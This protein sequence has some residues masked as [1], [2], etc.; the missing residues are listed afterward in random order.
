MRIV[1]KPLRSWLQATP[2]S[3]RFP[4][5]SLGVEQGQH[6]SLMLLFVLETSRSLVMLD[7]QWQHVSLMHLFMLLR[8]LA[9]SS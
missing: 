9:A 3:S 8:H 4:I 7:G 1:P 2:L 6:I 5:A